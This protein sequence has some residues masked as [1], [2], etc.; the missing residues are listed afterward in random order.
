MRRYSP[1]RLDRSRDM[2]QPPLLADATGRGADRIS[3]R[4]HEITFR[5]ANFVAKLP[6]NFAPG[7]GSASVFASV[8]TRRPVPLERGGSD[9]DGDVLR[10]RR[11]LENILDQAGDVERFPDEG[12][13]ILERIGRQ[14]ALVHAG[15]DDGRRWKEA[16]PIAI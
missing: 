7:Y 16:I 2:E 10:V 13:V 14:R 11:Q 6:R 3:W 9:H 4:R 1:A 8:F 12:G 5:S 15:V